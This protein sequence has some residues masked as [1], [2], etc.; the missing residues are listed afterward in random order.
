MV[1]PNHFGRLELEVT[2]QT[3][4]S[5]TVPTSRTT[6]GGSMIPISATEAAI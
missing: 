3:L 6:T 2:N 5:L 1:D 4:V